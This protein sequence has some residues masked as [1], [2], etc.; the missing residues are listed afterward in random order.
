MSARDRLRSYADPNGMPEMNDPNARYGRRY[1]MARYYAQPGHAVS[2]DEKALADDKEKLAGQVGALQRQAQQQAQSMSGARPDV[3]AKI[4][5]ALSEAEGKELALRLQKNAEWMR[6]GYGERNLSGE[7]SVT[8]GLQ[9]FGR[10]MRDVE[11]ALNTP[12]P[13]AEGKQPGREAP[14][15][16]RTP[17]VEQSPARYRDAVAGYFKKLSQGK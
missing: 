9:Q 6:Q 16:T 17:G 7:D 4:M 13:P 5:R 10:A 15:G 2:S 11:V 12:D 8:A 14:A 1:G 3:S